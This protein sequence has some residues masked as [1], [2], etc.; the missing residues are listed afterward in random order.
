MVGWV[1]KGVVLLV[2]AGLFWFTALTNDA[3]QSGSSDV[4]LRTLRAQPFGGELLAFVGVG[5]ACFGI[6]CFVWSR[7]ARHDV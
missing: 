2:V 1:V 5:L 3:A 4:A 7:H 6:F